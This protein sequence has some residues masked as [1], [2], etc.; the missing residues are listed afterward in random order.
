M[1]VYDESGPIGSETVESDPD[2]LEGQLRERLG[3]DDDL[4]DELTLADAVTCGGAVYAPVDD[5]TADEDDDEDGEDT[6]VVLDRDTARQVGRLVVVGDVLG[7][8]A[9]DGGLLVEVEVDGEPQ[10]VLYA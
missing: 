10:V 3:D 2:D 1:T 5:G 6:V 9:V 8:R 7:L 4:L